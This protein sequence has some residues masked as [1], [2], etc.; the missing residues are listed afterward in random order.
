MG[1]VVAE[2]VLDSSKLRTHTSSVEVIDTGVGG[3]AR[4]ATGHT[5]RHTSGHTAGHTSHASG[6][7]FT[8]GLSTW[9]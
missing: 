5:A 3:R 6:H 8:S 2:K 7:A 9:P 4:G 1:L